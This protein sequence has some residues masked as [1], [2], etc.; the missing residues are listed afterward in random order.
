MS[1]AVDRFIAELDSDPV[2]AGQAQLIRDW[3]IALD[4]QSDASPDSAGLYEAL[5]YLIAHPGHDVHGKIEKLHRLIRMR[6][7]VEGTLRA[8]VGW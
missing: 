7:R 4:L 5:H 2:F 3:F 1:V 8:I 6:G